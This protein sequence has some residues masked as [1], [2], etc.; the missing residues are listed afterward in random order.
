[1][2]NLQDY[3]VTFWPKDK[4]SE[5]IISLKIQEYNS[6]IDVSDSALRDLIK[7]E[8]SFFSAYPMTYQA[9]TIDDRPGEIGIITTKEGDYAHQNAKDTDIIISVQDHLLHL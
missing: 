9:I 4:S 3:P 6:E 7:E 8:A 2:R 1:L 5:G